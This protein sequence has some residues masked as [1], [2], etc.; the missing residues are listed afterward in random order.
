MQTTTTTQSAPI[1][2]QKINREEWLT[3]IGESIIDDIITPYVDQFE[4]GLDTPPVRYSVGFSPQSR[5]GK[6][7]GVCFP[8]S[9]SAD[10]HNEIF[11][12]PIVMDSLLVAGTLVHELIHAYLD[13]QDGHKGRFAKLA[14]ACG[15]EGK[16][17]ATYASN[18]LNERLQAYIDVL[19]PIPA[20]SLDYA[21]VKKQ[22]SR[23][24][25][26]ECSACGFLFRASSTQLQRLHSESACP[27]CDTVG[28]LE[29]EIK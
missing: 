29:P 10:R 20:Q 4:L 28:A 26:V 1:F 2:V 7:I 25:K 11:V 13:N 8:R 12:S 19:G 15:L 3:Q 16:L 23:Q 9:K 24:L 22:S 17:T 27:V 6:V 14:R 21:S 18:E 5:G